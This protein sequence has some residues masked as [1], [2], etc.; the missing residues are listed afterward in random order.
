MTRLS[1]PASSL[2]A[3]SSQVIDAFADTGTHS[4][5]DHCHSPRLRPEVILEL[6]MAVFDS[7]KLGWQPLSQEA[8]RQSRH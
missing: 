6:R 8:Y 5:E 4:G 1:M 2:G 3:A 7:K